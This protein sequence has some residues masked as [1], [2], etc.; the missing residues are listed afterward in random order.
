MNPVYPHHACPNCPWNRK[1]IGGDGPQPCPL[2]FIGEGPARDEVKV[3]LPFMG[4]AGKEFNLQYLP[5]AGLVRPEVRVDNATHCP[6]VNYDNPSHEMARHCSLK[7]LPQELRH[8]QPELIVLMGGVACSLADTHIDLDTD[9]GLPQH[10]SLLDGLWEGMVFPTFHPAAGLHEGQM[11]LQLRQDFAGLGQCL[12]GKLVAPVDDH[13]APVCRLLC[14][15]GEV[16][17]ALPSPLDLQVIG[18]VLEA[19]IDTESV[20]LKGAP[21]CLS[22][23]L[24]YDHGYVILADDHEG[25]REFFRWLRV[26]RVLVILHHSLH[27]IP[28][29]GAMG[30]TITRWRD[31]MVDAYHLAD[32]PQGLKA[33]G[34]RLLGVRMK[35][36]EDTVLPHSMVPAMEY[37]AEANV[38]LGGALTFHHQLKSGPRKGQWEERVLPG[39]DK[40]TVGAWRKVQKAIR[41]PG[42]D[43]WRRWDGW[44]PHDRELLRGLMG[45]ELPRPSIVHV[46]LEEAVAYAALDAVVTLRVHHKLRKRRIVL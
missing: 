22:F 1:P 29:I 20:S 46:P 34:W 37:L 7:H 6:M 5:L 45:R 40:A 9:H 30:G 19:A 26:N 31:T 15:A 18:P 35:S 32:V 2:L 13:P 4:R 16:A 24:D 44:H 28:V 3:G 12:K 10:N 11:I 25:L 17:A 14:G 42:A 27:D 8:T 33:L 36:F 21:W 38:V 39:A 23:A 41:E 43:P